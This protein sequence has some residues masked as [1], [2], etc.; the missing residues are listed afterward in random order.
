M[1]CPDCERNNMFDLERSIANWREQMLAAGIQSPV[2]LEELESHLRDEVAQEI[3]SG[4]TAQLAFEIAVQR[5]GRAGALKAEFK[6]D[7]IMEGILQQ[8]SV[9]MAIAF[10]FLACWFRFDQS[11]AIALAYGALLAGLI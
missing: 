9:W 4:S 3:A 2:P 1:S 5:I 11:P 10:A 7:G 8:K 6:K